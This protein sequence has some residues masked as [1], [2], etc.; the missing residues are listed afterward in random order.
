MELEHAKLVATVNEQRSLRTRHFR[1]RRRFAFTLVELLVV[2]AIIGVLVGL[3][4]PA[5][6]QAREAALRSQCIN[7]LKQIGIGVANYSETYQYFP[8]GSSGMAGVIVGNENWGVQAYLLPFIEREAVYNLANFEAKA[9][10]PPNDTIRQQFVQTYVCP[11]DV[12]RNINDNL[13]CGRSNYRACMGSDW[14]S[15]EMNNG[16][17]LQLKMLKPGDVTDGLSKTAMFSERVRGDGDV[18]IVSPEADYF[19]LP[20][21]VNDSIDTV[22]NNCR[23]LAIHSV[24]GSLTE[25]MP[26]SGRFWINGQL[27]TTRYNHASTPNTPSCARSGSGNLTP[28]NGGVVPPSSWHPGGVNVLLADG[29]VHFITDPIDIYVWRALGTRSGGETIQDF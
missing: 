15:G 22:Y 27:V 17:F 18:N 11:I 10:D 4:L 7:N 3:L 24:K 12:E 26:Y 1:P 9:G 14:I 8:T 13:N 21:S 25:Q 29:S 5:V 16:L 28:N 2:I 20:I 23:N 19:R 6:Q